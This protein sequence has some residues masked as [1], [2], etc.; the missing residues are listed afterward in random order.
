MELSACLAALFRPIHEVA[1]LLD[2]YMSAAGHILEAPSR[3]HLRTIFGKYCSGAEFDATI[4]DF[5]NYLA[6]V[7]VYHTAR[8]E[9]TDHANERYARLEVAWLEKK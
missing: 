8:H 1:F 6:S 7:G 2:P 9:V 4:K 3:E 5:N